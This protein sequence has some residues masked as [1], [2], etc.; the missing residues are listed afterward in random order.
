MMKLYSS[1]L[2]LYISS[3]NAKKENKTMLRTLVNVDPVNELRSVEEMFERFFGQPT[4]PV[5]AASTLPVDITEKD[6]NL[7]I[8]AAV[9]GID[10]KDLE[11]TI[12]SN[13]L[14]IRGETKTENQSE[15]EKIYRRE[16]SYGTFS[17]SIRLPE[18]LDLE[19]VSA[20]FNH[21]MVTITM[22][23][24]PEVKPQVRKVEVKNLGASNEQPSIEQNSQS[25]ENQQ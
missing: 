20:D 18:K 2:T 1:A 11:I 3:G 12:E 15:N 9:P 25:E 4:R 19:K 21:G 5:P 13:V 14:S 6:G 22:P 16:V 23:R 10:P 24:L 8:R 7:V 17:R